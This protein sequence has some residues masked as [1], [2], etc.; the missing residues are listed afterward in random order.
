MEAKYRRMTEKDDQYVKDHYEEKSYK[1]MANDLGLNLRQIQHAMHRLNLQKNIWSINHYKQLTSIYKNQLEK[2]IF[3]L[4]STNDAQFI[5]LIDECKDTLSEK[6]LEK[7][8]K[9]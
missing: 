4:E 9:L 8:G 1:E 2:V 7:V 3:E 5:N 6:T